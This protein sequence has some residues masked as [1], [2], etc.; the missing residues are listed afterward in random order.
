MC[1]I[2]DKFMMAFQKLFVRMYCFS[3][4]QRSQRRPFPNVR[5]SLEEGVEE[6]VSRLLKNLGQPGMSTESHGTRLD[7]YALLSN[8]DVR[9]PKQC[10]KRRVAVGVGRCCQSIDAHHQALL[11]QAVTNTTVTNVQYRIWRQRR[12]GVGNER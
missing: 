10:K 8:V 5:N 2:V 3:L 7:R 6:S 4:A 1:E 9:V 12:F 11:C